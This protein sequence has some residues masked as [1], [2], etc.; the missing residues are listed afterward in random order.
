M[1]MK[2]VFLT[3]LL[4]VAAVSSASAQ[5][6]YKKVFD[7]AI[8]VVNNAASNDQQIQVNQYKV[9]ALN[10]ISNLVKKRKLT[11]DSYFYDSQ[12]VNLA[13]FITDFETNIIKA[14]AISTEKRLEVIKVYRDASLQN[15]LFGDEDKETTFVYV[16]D[17]QT[18]TPFSLDTNWEK[19]YEQATANIKSVLGK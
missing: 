9:T 16:N 7:N 12:A 4:A 17:K 13:S 1:K 10:Y 8:A 11:K 14:R 18:Y 5:S 19:A 15:P 3:L 6:L 2:Q